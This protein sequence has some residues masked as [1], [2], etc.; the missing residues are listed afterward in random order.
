MLFDAFLRNPLVKKAVAAGEEQ[1]GRAVGK[2]LASEAVATGLQGLITAASTARQT[3]DAGVQRALKVA[4]LPSA[5]EVAS[6]Q[7]K[8][9]ELEAVIDR[10]ADRLEERSR[11][12]PPAGPGSDQGVSS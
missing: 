6:L 8:L 5:G 1:A 10:L 7:R 12:E 9:E 3:F 11:P 4:N 2:L